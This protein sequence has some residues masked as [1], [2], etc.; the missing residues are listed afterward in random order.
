[1][2]NLIKKNVSLENKARVQ[3]FC[4][5]IGKFP[6]SYKK[7][8]KKYRNSK[9]GKY[10]FIIFKNEAEGK[11][12]YALQSKFSRCIIIRSH[13]CMELSNYPRYIFERGGF[14]TGSLL[15]FIPSR[16]VVFY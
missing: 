2:Y 6:L 12:I 13:D 14:A 10:G 15:P 5:A 8:K 7:R 9:I 11:V 16:S 3:I 4:S 1:M